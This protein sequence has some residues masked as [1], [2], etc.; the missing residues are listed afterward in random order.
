ML[1]DLKKR[2][3]SGVRHPIEQR[4]G[5]SHR[6]REPKLCTLRQPLL[7]IRVAVGACDRVP[8]K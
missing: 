5:S 7:S 2:S 1:C 6:W 3:N 8:A 4:Y